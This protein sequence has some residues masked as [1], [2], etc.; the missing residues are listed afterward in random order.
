LPRR[1]EKN[2]H[3]RGRSKILQGGGR[4]LGEKIMISVD[5]LYEL[6]KA[7]RIIREG[8]GNENKRSRAVREIVFQ[9]QTLKER[10]S[11]YWG[12]QIKLKKGPE[13]HSRVV[14]DA[15]QGP[16]SRE[17][18]GRGIPVEHRKKEGRRRD[19]VAL[20]PQRREIKLNTGRWE[21]TPKTLE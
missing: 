20:I 10:G 18:E 9:G 11:A 15:D 6:H 3:K 8:N 17:T 2:V 7:Y 19:K 16:A 5:H 4:N 13:H 1:E 21:E 12:E 14:W